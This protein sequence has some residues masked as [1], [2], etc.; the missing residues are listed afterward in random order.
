MFMRHQPRRQF[1][2]F[3]AP[4]LAM[5][6]SA[7]L[8]LESSAIA[9][10]SAPR[11]VVAE[12]PAPVPSTA[13]APTALPQKEVGE[14]L[15]S[16]L[17]GMNKGLV[18]DSQNAYLLN[19]R[20]WLLATCSVDAIRNGTQAVA[21]AKRACE[22]TDF[23][24]ASHIDTLAA[25]YAET[26]DW[27][28]AI[29]W[30][31]KAIEQVSNAQ[32]QDFRS[33][34]EL[35]IQS[36]AHR[37]LEDAKSLSSTAINVGRRLSELKQYDEARKQFDIAI[38]LTPHIAS[39]WNWRGVTH[40]AIKDYASAL[41]DYA[42]A[43][44]LN[45]QTGQYVANK[46]A[47]LHRLGRYEE[48]VQAASKALEL[49][50]LSMSAAKDLES[51]RLELLSDFVQR[52][53][54]TSK[55]ADIYLQRGLQKSS[56]LEA[57]EEKIRNMRVARAISRGFGY[58]YTAGMVQVYL[59]KS[60]ELAARGDRNRA[61]QCLTVALV[62][63]KESGKRNERDCYIKRAEVLLAMGRYDDAFADMK[64]L[65]TDHAAT[66][67][68]E[69]MAQVWRK[70]NELHRVIELD[71]IY[72]KRAL[73]SSERSRTE[74][75][76]KALL[77]RAGH[78]EDMG[79]FGKASLDYQLLI[80]ALPKL[81]EVYRYLAQFHRRRNEIAKAIEEYGVALA[82]ADNSTERALAHLGRAQIWEA[83]NELYKAKADYEA[84]L[85]GDPKM[86]EAIRGKLRITSALKE[87]GAD[88][89][90]P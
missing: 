11:G 69:W 7:M 71:S 5:V 42:K 64:T 10:R 60:S 81:P 45:P 6:F 61:L 43:A 73:V 51:S 90:V 13:A 21:D 28:S 52:N 8:V 27:K 47:V 56:T 85:T 88:A 79:D 2:R 19:A 57:I 31:S 37:K 35:Y 16:I 68:Y 74:D 66:V 49:S 17:E 4:R 80:E 38:R 89:L 40:S 62:Y 32:K 58:K 20:A 54:L 39:T 36:K 34:L 86:T 76:K 77:R 63:G 29:Y 82:L 72:V 44:E 50:P 48:A 83:Q 15:R 12:N 18:I 70:R 24:E 59:E 46:A 1:L 87:D 30:Q 25:A 33:R 78:Y 41:R 67:N 22:F 75:L 84:A 3:L 65:A 55:D 53:N 9:Q 26:G 14:L 23:E